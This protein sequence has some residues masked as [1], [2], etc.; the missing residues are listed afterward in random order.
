[1]N[2]V[3]I[4][5][6][7][8]QKCEI[9]KVLAAK[10]PYVA[11]KSFRVKIVEDGKYHVNAQVLGESSVLL[12]GQALVDVVG[13][14][15]KVNI[16]LLPPNSES[17]LIIT[18]TIGVAPT[19]PPAPTPQVNPYPE[20]KDYLQYPG[21]F[22]TRDIKVGITSVNLRRLTAKDR[23]K[24]LADIISAN[25]SD[26]VKLTEIK[27]DVEVNRTFSQDFYTFTFSKPGRYIIRAQSLEI[28]SQPTGN[29][30]NMKPIANYHIFNVK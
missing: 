29:D 7:Q 2:D 4:K 20:I 13:G 28:W 21:T 8:P 26:G 1:E 18:T 24:Q 10:M 14:R 19:P 15:G 23:D 25:P 11:G 16:T 12:E 17:G 22:A 9:A 27:R 3:I 30:F 6:T 5:Q